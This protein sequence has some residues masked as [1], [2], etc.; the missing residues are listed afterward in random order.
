MLW[1][2]RGSSSVK[3]LEARVR[4]ASNQ[5]VMEPQRLQTKQ[6]SEAVKIRMR[7]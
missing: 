2:T 5:T 7:G 1:Q 6:K 3:G 4:R